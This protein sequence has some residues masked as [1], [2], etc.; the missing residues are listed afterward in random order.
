MHIP[1]TLLTLP[2]FLLPLATARCCILKAS[3]KSFALANFVTNCR[4]LCNG[5]WG[6]TLAVPAPLEDI[7]SKEWNTKCP[8]VVKGN[9]TTGVAH[10]VA[11]LCL[12]K[13]DLC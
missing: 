6:S 2:L 8:H 1:L 12:D 9:P 5:D 10:G 11:Y 7:T 3:S 4:T 13:D